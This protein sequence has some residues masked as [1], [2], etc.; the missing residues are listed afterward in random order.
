MSKDAASAA[1]TNAALTR[2]SRL[3]LCFSIIAICGMVVG[4]IDL[5][6]YNDLYFAHPSKLEEGTSSPSRYLPAISNFYYRYYHF[7]WMIFVGAVAW[8]GFLATRK[9]ATLSDYAVFAAV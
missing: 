4:C 5:I 3:I 8:G 6:S 9:R 2:T 1:E 7:S